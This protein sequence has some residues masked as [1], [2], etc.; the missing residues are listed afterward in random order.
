VT[1]DR[2]HTSGCFSPP[3]FSLPPALPEPHKLP[4]P[5]TLLR[6]PRPAPSSSRQPL[7]AECPSVTVTVVDTWKDRIDAWNAE[8]VDNLPVFEP[9][10]AEGVQ[11]GR[12]RGNLRFSTDVE[13]HVAEADIIFVSVNTPTKAFGIGAGH[14]SNVKNI[15]LCARL[16]ASVCDTPKIIVEKSTVPVKTAETLRR[17]LAANKK[18]RMRRGKGEEEGRW[19][20]LCGFQKGLHGGTRSH[21]SPSPRPHSH[22]LPRNQN[23]QGVH[24]EILSNPEFLAEGTAIRDLEN[25]S[26]VLIG[27]AT[28]PGGQ[29]AV[30]TLSSVYATW[31]PREKIIT[32]NLWSSELSKLVANAFLAQRISSINSVSA[33]CEATDADVDEVARAVGLDP[34]IGPQFLKA[35]VGFGGS[36]FQKDILNLVY[37]CRSYGL[38]EVA[39]YWEHVVKLNDYQKAR[40]AHTMVERMFSTIT[41]KRIAILGFAFKKDTGDVRESAAAYVAKALLQERAELHVYDPKVRRPAMLEEMSYTCGVTPATLPELESLLLTETDAYEACRGSHAVAIL[42]EWD[43]FK[44]LDWAR[45]YDGMVKPAFVFDG[46]N[47]LDH[48]AL[49]SIGFEVYAV[50]KGAHFGTTDGGDDE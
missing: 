46:R 6:P 30:A 19:L 38:Q 40:F 24:H 43:S 36:C 34:R 8:D 12:E 42:T 18:V 44:T 29:A 41:G 4:L 7:P 2:P 15:E 47:I 26:R 13:K 22:L 45:I 33:L 5:L 35:S 32:T 23:S 1:Q 27:G 17:V 9:G 39:D 37:L 50:G 31:V 21:S 14:A 16:I 48:A 10:L 11:K 25:P 20:A 28:T 49:H 3:A